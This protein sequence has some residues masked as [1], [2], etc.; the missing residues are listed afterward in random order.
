M[1]LLPEMVKAVREGEISTDSRTLRPGELFIALTGERFDGH[2]YLKEAVQK[3]ASAL[4]ISNEKAAQ[5]LTGVPK[6]VVS[7]TRRAL[8]ELAHRHRNRFRLPVVAVTGS[9]GKTSTKEMIASALS[10]RGPVLKSEG[11]Q[12]NEIGVPWTLLKLRNEHWAAVIEMG[13]N[14]HG[15]I[16]HLARIANPG[17]GVI[18]NAAAAHLEGLGSVERVAEAKC[19]LLNVMG[20]EG[21]AVINGDD[22]VLLKAAR[23]Y[24][25]RRMTFGLNSSCDIRLEEEAFPVHLRARFQK[26]NLLAVLAV[27]RLLDI[28][29]EEVL[30]I[31]SKWSPP[32]RRLQ[33]K[34][35]EGFWVIDDTYNANPLSMRAAI[36]CLR[37]FQTAGR[38]I[39]VLSDMLE[40][41]GES[42]KWHYA[43]GEQAAR[44]GLD[45]LFL[46]GEFSKETQRGAIES[47]MRPA[48]I[49]LLDSHQEILDRV[50]S[51][52]SGQDVILVKGSRRMKMERIV[53]GLLSHVLSS[54]LSFT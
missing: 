30:K 50:R 18:T 34:K 12:N 53:E 25:C 37:D 15:E 46:M 45:Q 16:E 20:R 41:G 7:D 32:E 1:F 43:S 11:T 49:H 28:P 39:A 21:T 47:G 54:A 14:H 19:E 6:I 8:G 4:M 44:A 40:L 52:I 9:C 38:R 5:D 22:P 48:S 10:F 2:D 31:L 23:K 27:A 24:P 3:G 13:M 42:G 17:I 51:Q 29:R 33:V 26:S 36:D 35:G